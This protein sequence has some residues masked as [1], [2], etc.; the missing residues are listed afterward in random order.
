MPTQAEENKRKQEFLL[1]NGVNVKV[2]G[3]WVL[4]RKTIQKVNY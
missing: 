2:D 4:G 1:R 3:S